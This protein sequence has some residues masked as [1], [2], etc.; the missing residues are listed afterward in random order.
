MA[1]T[2]GYTTLANVTARL[3]ALSVTASA[4]DDA[5]IERLVENASRF[6]DKETHRTFYARTET[7]YYN[8][9]EDYELFILD[10]ELLT[11][12]TL[13]NGD[14]TVITSGQYKLYPLNTNPKYIIRLL[15]SAGIAWTFSSAGDVEA[16]I[17]VAGT[18]GY[19]ASAPE[20]IREACEQIVMTAYQGRRG[21]GTQGAV[22]VTASGVVIT[23]QDVPDIA[24][25]TI[26]H[27]T[28][29]V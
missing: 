24:L 6:I 2:N 21:D 20:D 7:H 3:T 18:W 28:R 1:I 4:T 15:P 14:A 5:F 9:P 11:I 25:K 17:T 27:Y 29:I 16:A 10:D 19:S 12:S 23:P 13:T 26:G 8:T 22:T